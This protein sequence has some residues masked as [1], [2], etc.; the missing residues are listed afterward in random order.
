[1]DKTKRQQWT[2]IPRTMP[3]VKRNCT[4]CGKKS[5]FQNSGKFRVNAN[6]R[7]VDVWL[8][9]RCVKCKTV[10]NMTIYERMDAAA[11]TKEEYRGFMSNHAE[12]AEQYGTDADIFIQ[13]KAE[14]VVEDIEY[15]IKTILMEQNC[16]TENDAEIE[17]LSPAY[18]EVRVDSLLAKQLGFSRSYVKKCC[19]EGLIY[20]EGN[21]NIA[22]T[23][24]N[25]GMVIYIAST[26]F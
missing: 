14:P 10:W 19:K 26:C 22:K 7:L 3:K 18:M 6:G 21:K 24:I 4:K 1:M 25:S 16:E 11:I 2:I 13:N 20:Q 5:N 15:D 17:F 9:Y 8:I 23:K 12:L